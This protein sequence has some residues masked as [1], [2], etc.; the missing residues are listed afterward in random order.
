MHVE[1]IDVFAIPVVKIQMPESES[2]KQQYLPEILK[3]YEAGDFK[4]PANEVV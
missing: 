4:K 3:R 2:L 1:K